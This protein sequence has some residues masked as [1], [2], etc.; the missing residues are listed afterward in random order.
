MTVK[1]RNP[2]D[3]TLRNIRALKTRVAALERHVRSL[4]DEVFRVSPRRRSPSA[5][6]KVNR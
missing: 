5:P 3:A 4:I 2:Q 6:L 1:K